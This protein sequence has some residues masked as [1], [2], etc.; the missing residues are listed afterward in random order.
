[1]VKIAT[2]AAKGAEGVQLCAFS[3]K[4]AQP[5]IVSF[6]LDPDQHFAS[7]MQIAK[8]T[9]PSEKAVMVDED[10]KFAASMMVGSKNE[11]WKLRNEAIQAVRLLKSRWRPVTAKLRSV[12]QDG[13]QASH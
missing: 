11:L 13:P 6:G 2:R 1:M 12:Q 5:P 4:A 7:S 10:L 8:G 9:L 3:H